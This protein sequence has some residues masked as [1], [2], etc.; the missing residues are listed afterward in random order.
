M[1][2]GPEKSVV[3]VVLGIYPCFT[4]GLEIFYHKHI[5]ELAE[6][7][8]IT[9]I[10]CCSK[11]QAENV[12]II[13]IP[14][15]FFNIKG[16]GRIAKL[17]YTAIAITK[18]RKRIEYVH[19]PYTSNAG[20]W[21]LIFPLLSLFW[22]VKYILYNHGGGM[23]KWKKFSFD[24]VL[25]KYAYKV[26][27]VS[28]ILKQEYEKRAKRA[29]GV[30]YP[31]TKFENAT[32]TN[33]KIR[34]KW[35]IDH[36]VKII[37]FVG[38]LKSLKMP[39][40]LLNAFI[41]LGKDYVNQQNLKLIFV[42]DG[43]MKSSLIGLVKEKAFDNYVSFAGKVSNEDIPLYYKI[44]NY[45]IITS[46]FEGTPISLLEAMFNGL[47]IIGSRVNGIQNIIKHKETGLLFE[48]GN[49]E[50][51]KEQIQLLIQDSNLA[52]SAALAAH[53]EYNERFSKMNATAKFLNI[54]II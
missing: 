7:Q 40:T 9:L 32:D 41:S 4:G 2:K 49:S 53:C 3:Y 35:H 50:N 42:G 47:P 33:E 18:Q 20:N 51:L 30:V 11:F 24:K 13:Q 44:A 52:K 23:R 14:S 8:S 6:Q 27:A 34:T 28:T 46:K 15:R 43:V 25:Y 10:T 21:G 22:G 38:S 39:D 37:L 54:E 36:S 29:I 1:E 45:Y 16:T 12:N 31:L 26:F 19:V 48:S 5:R 17:I